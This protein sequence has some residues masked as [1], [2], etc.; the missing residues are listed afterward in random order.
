MLGLEVVKQVDWNWHM[1][2]YNNQINIL[3]RLS[4]A[5]VPPFYGNF[6]AHSVHVWYFILDSTT[7][8]AFLKL[9]TNYLSHRINLLIM[10]F[11]YL[12]SF[13]N[14]VIITSIIIYI[15]IKSSILLLVFRFCI[16]YYIVFILLYNFMP[17]AIIWI[18]RIQLSEF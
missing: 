16:L 14:N 7:A 5:K 4:P 13:I 1:L 18:K 10:L 17:P 3:C 2:F 6:A 11:Y 15:F 8:F 9:C 12:Y